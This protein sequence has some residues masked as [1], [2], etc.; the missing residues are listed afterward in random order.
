MDYMTENKSPPYSRWVLA[1]VDKKHHYTSIAQLA[2][3]CADNAG[4][5]GSSPL[6]RTIAQC[7]AKSSHLELMFMIVTPKSKSED[8][9][10]G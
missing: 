7:A 2:E 9:P 3:H 1:W 4:V 6:I 5:S 8:T 10:A